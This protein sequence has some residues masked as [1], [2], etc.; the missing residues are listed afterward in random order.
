VEV[1]VRRSPLGD[2]DPL[3]DVVD[4]VQFKRIV[5]PQVGNVVRGPIEGQRVGHD[6]GAPA[7]AEL[8]D[9]RPLLFENEVVEELQISQFGP[10]G[11]VGL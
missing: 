4:R 11:R 5:P 2:I 8:Q 9:S 10:V 6:E 1:N 7:A 3:L